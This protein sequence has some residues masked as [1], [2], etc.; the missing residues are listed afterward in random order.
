MLWP[1][2]PQ[3]DLIHCQINL[4]AVTQR[5]RSRS[6]SNHVIPGR[7]SRLPGAPS[8]PAAA[9]TSSAAILEADHDQDHEQHAK[10]LPAWSTL[11]AAESKQCQRDREREL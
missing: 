10:H 11:H 3:S 1:G 7:C 5:T 4:S 6:D 2:T 9:A 8:T